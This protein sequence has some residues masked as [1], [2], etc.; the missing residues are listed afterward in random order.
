MPVSLREYELLA[1]QATAG[2]LTIMPIEETL[3]A[4]A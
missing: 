3:D 4:A 1:I 2:T